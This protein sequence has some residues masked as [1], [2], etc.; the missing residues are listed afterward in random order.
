MDKNT[1]PGVSNPD[2]RKGY[3]YDRIARMETSISEDYSFLQFILN[4]YQDAE[5]G[6]YPY[7][8]LNGNCSSQTVNDINSFFGEGT[9]TNPNV[10]IPNIIFDSLNK[11][12]NFEIIQGKE[13]NWA[14]Q[15]NAKEIIEIMIGL[16]RMDSNYFDDN[17]SKEYLGDLQQY[18]SFDRIREVR[19]N[20]VNQGGPGQ[21]YYNYLEGDDNTSESD[22]PF[23]IETLW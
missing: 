4:K 20:N 1:S 17:F 5:N 21:D 13:I 8:F 11:N 6:S 18:A 3:G 22:T 2:S 10:D 7:G 23:V 16:Q 12:P 14:E 9:I 19:K 15:L